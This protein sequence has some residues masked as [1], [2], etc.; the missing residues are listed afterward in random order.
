MSEASTL[1]LPPTGLG[2]YPVACPN[3]RALPLYFK[4]KRT[5]GQQ[6]EH[7]FPQ[8]GQLRKLT[9]ACITQDL[10][11]LPKMACQSFVRSK[12]CLLLPSQV[13]QYV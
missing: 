3:G 13:N 5:P 10:E 6:G 8:P 11:E 1:R 12:H 9:A 2:P 7:T 4:P